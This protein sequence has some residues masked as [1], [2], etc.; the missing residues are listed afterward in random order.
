[1]NKFVAPVVTGIV[2]ALIAGAAGFYGGMTYQSS[3]MPRF[4]GQGGVPGGTFRGRMFGQGAPG[5][6]GPNG[7]Q[8][9][10]AAGTVLAS[11]SKSIT[12]K[13][14]GGGSKIVY[15]SSEARITRSAEATGTDLKTGQN[16]I[17]GGTAGSDG[18]ITA[19]TIQIVPEGMMQRRA[20]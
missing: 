11:D 18:S 4:T 20:P 15:F 3:R 13:L 5:A 10:F 19:R 9:G 14:P 1:M 12:V 2:V 6:P 8:G 16:V 7:A 17:V